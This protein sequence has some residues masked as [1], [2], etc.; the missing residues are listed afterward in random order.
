MQF[1]GAGLGGA[2]VGFVKESLVEALS[3]KSVG[4]GIGHDVLS[5]MGG[6]SGW[7]GTSRR[8]DREDESGTVIGNHTGR[9]SDLDWKI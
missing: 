1:L 3:H 6:F 4:G 7:P 5:T 9:E 2:K 8:N